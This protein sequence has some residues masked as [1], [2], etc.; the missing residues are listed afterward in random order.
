MLVFSSLFF[1]HPIQSSYLSDVMMGI[2]LSI[3]PVRSYYNQ[4][5]VLIQT[6]Q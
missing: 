6:F 3:M 1:V 4:G 5:F 2:G